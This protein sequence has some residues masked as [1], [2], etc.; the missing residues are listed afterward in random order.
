MIAHPDTPLTSVTNPYCSI[1][2][3]L[4]LLQHIDFLAVSQTLQ[5]HSHFKSFTVALLEMLLP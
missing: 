5:A 1:L 2:P 3:A 4:T